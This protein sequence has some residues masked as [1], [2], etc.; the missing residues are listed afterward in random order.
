MCQRVATC[1]KFY[2]EL[3][4]KLKIMV[5]KKVFKVVGLGEVLWDMLPS[6]RELG[7]APANFTYHAAQLGADATLISAIG[8]DKLG[9]E[10]AALLK[11]KRV[12]HLLY[13]SSKPTG[14]VEVT[15]K[16]GIPFYDIKANVAWDDLVIIPQMAAAVA[17]ADAICFGTLA[18]RGD[19]SR[20]SIRV[21]LEMAPVDCLLVFDINLRQHFYS[22]EIIE[23]S[24]FY[25]NILK[26][27]EDELEVLSEMF[28]LA[29]SPTDRC[30][31]LLT[32]FGLA[33]VVLTLGANGS[34]LFAGK[35]K[36]F[37]AAPKVAVADTVGA[38]DAFTAALV[39][40]VLREQ[41]LAEIHRQA[42]TLSAFVCTQKG[43][44]PIYPKELRLH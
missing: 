19:M 12:N 44:M 7:G 38:G 26:V 6:G 34:F 16:E 30:N 22:R 9:Q 42:V 36:S 39:D 32:G 27:N 24:L 33:M 8:N 41:K 23:E 43:A 17:A 11:Q 1:S 5:K 4:L 40:G 2:E 35:E 14:T 13:A 21:L 37:L 20:N 28:G 10:A 25:A 3:S 15:L 18:Q 31:A 29:G